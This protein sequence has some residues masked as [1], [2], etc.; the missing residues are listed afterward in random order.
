MLAV[1]LYQALARRRGSQV[2]PRAS[3]E[4]VLEFGLVPCRLVRDLWLTA[5]VPAPRR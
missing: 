4:F 5:G 3:E 2:D 1:F